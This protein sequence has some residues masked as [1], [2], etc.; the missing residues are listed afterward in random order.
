MFELSLQDRSIRLAELSVAIR[1][2]GAAGVPDGVAVGVGVAL[3]VVVGVGVG[4]DE[5]F[6]TSKLTEIP[7]PAVP[8]PFVAE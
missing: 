6:T 3:G 1:F 7:V 8:P 4:V 5:V 2:D